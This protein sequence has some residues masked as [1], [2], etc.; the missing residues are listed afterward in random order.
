LLRL[1]FLEVDYDLGRGGES[2]DLPGAERKLDALDR[3]QELG[4]NLP[5]VEPRLR[6]LPAAFQPNVLFE[7][8]RC[9]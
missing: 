3:T 4:G 1:V 7:A 9:R 8:Q 6:P 5:V 2:R